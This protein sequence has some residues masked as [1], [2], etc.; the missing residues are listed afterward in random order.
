MKSHFFFA[1][2]CIVISNDFWCNLVMHWLWAN[3][4]SNCYNST[5]I[6]PWEITELCI[7]NTILS[8]SELHHTIFEHKM[9]AMQPAAIDQN[10]HA[11]LSWF[12]MQ[13]FEREYDG[14]YPIMA[15]DG[16][17]LLYK[18]RLLYVHTVLQWLSL[19]TIRILCMH[20]VLVMCIQSLHLPAERWVL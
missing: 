20:T 18:I 14:L 12:Y 2:V 11:S 3:I 15:Q 7:R 17:N 1:V 5:L 10:M 4:V 8:F 16:N 6:M 9:K 19:L 13:I